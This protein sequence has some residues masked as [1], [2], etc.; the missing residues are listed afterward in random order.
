VTRTTIKSRAKNSNERSIVY[1]NAHECDF[2]CAYV[3]TCEIRTCE[4]MHNAV[5][6]KF[7][8]KLVSLIYLLRCK[9]DFY[10]DSRQWEWR[11]T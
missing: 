7:W 2:V 10:I 11:V 4:F 9:N 3:R 8:L 1:T 6:S 5:V